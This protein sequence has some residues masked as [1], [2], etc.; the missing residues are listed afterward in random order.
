MSTLTDDDR[1]RIAE[2]V[3]QA[4]S[5]TAAEFVPVLAEASDRYDRP[6]DIAGLWL[7]AAVMTGVWF[8]LPER[9][10]VVGSWGDP[11]RV[12][13]LVILLASGLLA[14]LAGAF[15]ASQRDAI[16]LLFTPRQ[17]MRDAV[18]RA[19]AVTFFDRRVHHAPSRAGLLIY[20]SEFERGAAVLADRTV[21]RALGETGL[22]DLRDMLTDKL[23]VNG[24]VDAICQTIEAAAARLEATLPAGE[25]DVN[26][27]ADA[28]VECGRP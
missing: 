13:S 8:L 17:Q 23:A 22:Q 7:A 18:R 5:R 10:P 26:E 3:H 19:A 27:I 9:A 16:R 21:L 6:E 14:F 25:D 2:V 28:L 20:V 4:E 12:F 24:P 11:A 15:A 1:R